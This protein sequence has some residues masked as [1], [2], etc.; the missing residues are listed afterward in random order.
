MTLEQLARKMYEEQANR[1]VPPWDSLTGGTR[2]LWMERAR[3]EMAR[4]NP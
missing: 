4:K 1:V 3:V 2:E